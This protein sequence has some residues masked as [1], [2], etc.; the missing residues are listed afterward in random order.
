M[1]PP[2]NQMVQ[3]LQIN[4]QYSKATSTNLL[5]RL[6]QKGEN[7]ILVQEPWAMV[8]DLGNKLHKLIYAQGKNRPRSGILIDKHIKSLP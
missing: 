2:I 7:I 3:A 5:F 8:W 4:M 6:Q 1:H